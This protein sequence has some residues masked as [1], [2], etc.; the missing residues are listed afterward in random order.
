MKSL[1]FA[2]LGLLFLA[3]YY[4]TNQYDEACL[5]EQAHRFV[6]DGVVRSEFYRGLNH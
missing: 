1:F 5:A 3:F 2:F 4:R 6:K